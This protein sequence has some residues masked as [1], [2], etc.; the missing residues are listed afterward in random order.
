MANYY[1][2]SEVKE[3]TKLSTTDMMQEIRNA[4]FPA[5]YDLDGSPVWDKGAVDDWVDDHQPE[6]ES[7]DTASG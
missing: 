4:R 3:L 7:D 2:R 6:N 1:K 5:S